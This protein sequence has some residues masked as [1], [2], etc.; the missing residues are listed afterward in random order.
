MNSGVKTQNNLSGLHQRDLFAPSAEVTNA[1]SGVSESNIG[2]VRLC[3]EFWGFFF[4]PRQINIV[5]SDS[6]IL[7]KTFYYKLSLLTA[8]GVFFFFSLTLLFALAPGLQVSLSH[9][10]LMPT[11]GK[12][13]DH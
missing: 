10:R 9:W 1:V 13:S 11:G 4:S 3:L 6:A 12:E 7:R 2:H 5:W 8:F